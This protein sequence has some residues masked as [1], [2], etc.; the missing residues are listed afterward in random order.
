MPESKK[1]GKKNPEL[2]IKE[3]QDLIKNLPVDKARK[4]EQQQPK[5]SM[6]LQPNV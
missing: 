6:G 1:A 5:C 2:Y 4:M 3:T